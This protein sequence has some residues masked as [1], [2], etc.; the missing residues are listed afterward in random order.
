[1][2]AITT[3]E[4]NSWENLDGFMIGRAAIGNPWCFQDRSKYPLPTQF[5]RIEV[6]LE[7][8]HLFRRFKQNNCSKGISQVSRQL[9]EWIPQRQRVA[10]PIDAVP[11]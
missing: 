3:M 7:H 11:G 1:M 6:A 4:S 8:F 5:K 9:C 10:Q 2:S